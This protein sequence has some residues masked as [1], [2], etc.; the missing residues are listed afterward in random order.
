MNYL[1]SFFGQYFLFRIIFA[2]IALCFL[3]E[4]VENR[5]EI[6]L[7]I[8]N[9]IILIFQSLIIMH[10]LSVSK[11]NH[12]NRILINDANVAIKY[13]YILTTFIVAYLLLNDL[14][15]IFN[16][17]GSDSIM[18]ISENAKVSTWFLFSLLRI[19]ALI[20]LVNF[21]LSLFFTKNK[22]NYFRMLVIS[23]FII[24]I[25]SL[26]GK[27]SSILHILGI[28]SFLSLVYNIKSLTAFKSLAFT[29]V[30]ILFGLFQYV[31]T[32]NIEFDLFSLLGKVSNITFSSFTNIYVLIYKLD[33]YKLYTDYYSNFSNESVFSYYFNSYL[34]IFGLGGI[35]KSIGPYFAY[36]QLGQHTLNGVNPT[37]IVETVFSFGS[38]YAVIFA[39]LYLVLFWAAVIYAILRLKLKHYDTVEVSFYIYVI[40]ILLTSLSD[41]LTAMR[42]L[43]FLA[44]FYIFVLYKRI[45][46]K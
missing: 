42:S 30:A 22:R 10:A 20:I 13:V 27:K 21:Y 1:L 2:M 8:V 35:E 23:I 32:I 12:A 7:Y 36:K 11:I 41:F 6:F 14:L 45:W 33:Y 5:E 46:T 39:V 15:P 19:C 37:L 40:M 43:P 24:F 44:L 9:I 28:I 25:F 3:A 34:K 29:G 31:R 26:T 17:N 18:V 16:E 38:L 4:Y